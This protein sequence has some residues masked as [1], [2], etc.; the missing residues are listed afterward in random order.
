MPLPLILGIAAGVA[1]IAGVGAGVKGAI[2]IADANDTLNK[3]KKRDEKNQKRHKNIDEKACKSMDKLGVLEMNILSSFK[4]FADVIEKIKNRPS[5]ADIKIGNV[6]IP[7]YNPKELEQAS[8]GAGILVGGLGGAAL[9]TAGGFAASGA[10]TAAVMALG[11][12]STG[13]A[14]SS[15][16][17]VA[18]TNAT[19]AALGGGSIAAGGGGMALGSAVLGGATLGVG[20]L[21]GGVIFSLVGSNI[22]D[23]AD[24]AY[25]QMLENEKV[26]NKI[27]KYLEELNV[28]AENYYNDLNMANNIYK[29]QFRIMSCIVDNKKEADGTVEWR[30]LRDTEKTTINNVVML[31]GLLYYMC[32]VKLVNKTVGGNQINTINTTDINE[33]QR[34]CNET[35]K[36]VNASCA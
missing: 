8:V 11:T 33:A 7:K 25:S 15:L 24:K 23:K 19:L 36:V 22:S 20:L 17:G 5:F 34:K 35:L 30:K 1:A 2:D 3:A 31:V 10:T 21:V 13:T 32:K 14:I 18:A 16:T 12:A 6:E 4:Q 9:G 27:C 29:E 26:I 28:A